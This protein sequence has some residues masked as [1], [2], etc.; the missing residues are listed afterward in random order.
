M[1]RHGGNRAVHDPALILQES[2][3]VVR[4][5]GEVVVVDITS[6]GSP[7][8]A[9]IRLGLRYLRRWGRPPAP[10]RNL[11]L[12][13]LV[14]LKEQAGFLVKEQA[15]IGSTVKAACLGVRKRA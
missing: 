11:S 8:L 12:D 4:N 9:G 7:L 14:R 10:G 15:L 13:E 6:Q 2:N 3:R 5:D 1:Q